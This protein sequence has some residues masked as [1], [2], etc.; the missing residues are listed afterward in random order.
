MISTYKV[1]IR[2]ER[3]EYVRVVVGSLMCV[4]NSIDNKLESNRQAIGIP[5]NEKIIEVSYKK[6]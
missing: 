2:S 4:M 3:K 1:T 5:F 6:Y